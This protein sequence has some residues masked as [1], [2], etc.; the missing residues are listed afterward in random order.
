MEQVFSH[1]QVLHRNMLCQV[2][3]P[4]YGKLPQLGPAVKYSGFNVAA[5]WI[6][7]PLLGEHTEEVLGEWLAMNDEEIANLKSA[8]VV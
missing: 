8:K 4:S 1:R 2:E 5:G 3:H 7:P 6:A